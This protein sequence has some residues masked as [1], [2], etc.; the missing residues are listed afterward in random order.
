M[1]ESSIITTF[2]AV[3]GIIGVIGL[4]IYVTPTILNAFES[5]AGDQSG[6]ISW[7][8]VA[9]LAVGVF[10]IVFVISQKK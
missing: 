8:I 7:V 5:L 3:I 6:T 1:A 2:V 9:L 4:L 10:G